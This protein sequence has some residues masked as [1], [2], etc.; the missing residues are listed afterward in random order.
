MALEPFYKQW[1]KLCQR[2]FTCTAPWVSLNF[3]HKISIHKG[4]ISG[5][6]MPHL[7]TLYSHHATACQYPQIK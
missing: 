2:C 3:T 4:Y 6:T 5:L 1:H 7:N